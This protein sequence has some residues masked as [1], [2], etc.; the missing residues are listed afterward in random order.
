MKDWP[1]GKMCEKRT[2]AG[3][4]RPGKSST[5]SSGVPPF[6]DT[7]MILVWPCGL[8]DLVWVDRQ[9]NEE[10]LTTEP[11]NYALPVLS[12]DGSM[13]AYD[14]AGVNPDIHTHDIQT[15]ISRQETFFAGP[16]QL[17]VWGPDGEQL[18]FVSA[19]GEAN[20]DIYKMRIDPRGEPVLVLTLPGDLAATS[21][22]RDGR[23]IAFRP[24]ACGRA[25]VDITPIQRH[26]R[27]Y[28]TCQTPLK[29]LIV[30]QEA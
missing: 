1:S 28:R 8:S 23:T 12:P 29:S 10:A 18:S 3:S 21:W 26:W 24:T 25:R 16:D 17:P 5:T 7:L 19:R 15:G 13:V 9:G 20:R 27:H 14:N 11:G 30:R 4:G 6:S 22:S 2:K